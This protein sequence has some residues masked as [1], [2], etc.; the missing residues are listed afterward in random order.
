MHQQRAAD[1]DALALAAGQVAGA[2]LQQMAD[3][4]HVHDARVRRVVARQAI[5]P[6][7]VVQVLRHGHMREQAAVLKHIADVP[8]VRWLIGAI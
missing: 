4:E 3:V 6:P 5:H 2:P 7:P 1:R 8:A